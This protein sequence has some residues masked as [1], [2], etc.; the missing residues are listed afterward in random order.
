MKETPTQLLEA[1]QS[2][3]TDALDSFMRC[4]FAEMRRRARGLLLQEAAGHTL[5]P[6]ALVNEAFLRLFDGK[7]IP[8]ANSKHF[9]MSASQEMR[10]ALVDHARRA[11]AEKRR[12][13]L[14]EPL[15][16]EYP[17]ANSTM[18]DE[19]LDI[20]SALRDLALESQ[21][22]VT[23][24]EMRFFGGLE[25]AEIARVLGVT[26]RTIEREWAWARAWLLRRLDRGR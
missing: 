23:V 26:E 19:C 25:Q 11:T 10:R 13:D 21:R 12:R 5:Q 7:P 1:M 24:V 4:V 2:G 8:W 6:T 3:C 14:Y 9:L 16:F 22:A 15:D 20:D 18:L 17:S